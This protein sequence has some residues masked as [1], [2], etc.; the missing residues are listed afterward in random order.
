MEKRTESVEFFVAFDGEK[1]LNQADCE[2]HEAKVQALQKRMAGMQFFVLTY[3]PDLTEGRGFYGR[4][5]IAIDGY[6]QGYPVRARV[7]KA[8]FLLGGDPIQF[9][10]GAAPMEGWVLTESTA[11]RWARRASDRPKVGDYDHDPEELF[12]SDG[13]GIDGFPPPAFA[14]QPQPAAQAVEIPF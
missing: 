14:P 6:P 4:V 7:L 13:S 3:R 12:L 9:V 10:Q 1:F 11:E 2:K 5:H 8:A